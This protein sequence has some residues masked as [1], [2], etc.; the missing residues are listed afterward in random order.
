MRL[1]DR[2]LFS[3]RRKMFFLH[4]SKCATLIE[5]KSQKNPWG[6]P[7]GIGQ[8]SYYGLVISPARGTKFTCD[9]WKARIGEELSEHRQYAWGKVQVTSI[10]K[11]VSLPPTALGSLIK[12]PAVM[13][14]LERGI[15]PVLITQAP[16][17]LKQFSAMLVDAHAYEAA[18]TTGTMATPYCGPVHYATGAVITQTLMDMFAAP[19]IGRRVC[20]FCN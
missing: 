5:I 8:P 9:H 3:I 7:I 4:A 12:D 6:I 14:Q 1:C 10:R 18:A 16:N 17:D 2:L 20:V 11:L 19:P 15:T 13:N